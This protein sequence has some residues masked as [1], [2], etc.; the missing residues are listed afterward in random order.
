MIEIYTDGACS[1]NP[2]PGG[3]AAVIVRDGET[4]EIGGREARTTSNRM[5]LRAALEALRRV[6]A[7]EPVRLFSDSQYLV[8]GMTSWVRGWKRRGWV[9]VEGRPV[10]NRDLWEELD[11]AAGTRVAWEY[12]RGHTGHTYNERANTIAQAYAAGRQ[13][14]PP[15]TPTPG[16]TGRPPGPS[17]LSLVDG[18]LRRHATWEDCRARVERVS[19]ARFKKCA[20]AADEAAAV[21]AWGLPPEALETLGAEA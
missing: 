15:G 6:P 1:G 9:T 11:R 21:A 19:G 7:G 13:P 16:G 17:Y 18:V 14:P 2:G 4:E 12:V 10:E 3:W 8:N 5:E 20:S